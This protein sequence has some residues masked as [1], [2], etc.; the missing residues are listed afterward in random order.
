VRV[1]ARCIQ[2]TP[3][4]VGHILPLLRRRNPQGSSHREISGSSPTKL[5]AYI[6]RLQKRLD[7]YCRSC[8]AYPLPGLLPM[9]SSI[10]APRWVPPRSPGNVGCGRSRKQPRS[11]WPNATLD[12][13]NPIE[14]IE[15]NS[16]PFK[17]M[18]QILIKRSHS[19]HQACFQG[20]RAINRSL[21][22]N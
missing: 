6:E 21:S 2:P 14:P 9:S 18:R 7:K 8:Y 19:S 17:K 12:Q 11:L 4:A 20:I 15:V 5:L 16:W 13:T 10:R 22:G 1:E 3:F